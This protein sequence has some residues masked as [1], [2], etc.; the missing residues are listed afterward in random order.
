MYDICIQYIC[1]QQIHMYT[2]VYNKYMVCIYMYNADCFRSYSILMRGHRKFLAMITEWGKTHWIKRDRL[3]L[4]FSP[5][6]C[7]NVRALELTIWWTK[8][9]KCVIGRCSTHIHP[10]QYRC[11]GQCG[12]H[13]NVMSEL[14]MDWRQCVLNQSGT[15]NIVDGDHQVPT[16]IVDRKP[17]CRQTSCLKF[18]WHRQTLCISW[19]NHQ[20]ILNCV[21]DFLAL[22]K[23]GC[24]VSRGGRLGNNKCYFEWFVRQT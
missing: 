14:F 22:T 3:S 19:V 4:W 11:M 24:V 8:P 2:H 5:I 12:K 9:H 23:I 13:K 6:H 15:G 18:V 16:N 17:R 7:D 10:N 1:E 20:H 21:F